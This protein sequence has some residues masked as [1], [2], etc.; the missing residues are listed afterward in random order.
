MC[1]LMLLVV[2]GCCAG[3]VVVDCVGYG[4]DVVGVVVGFLLFSVVIV[5]V[6]PPIVYVSDVYV[7]V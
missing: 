4:C 5:Y 7:H 2:V 6:R 3:V 1:L